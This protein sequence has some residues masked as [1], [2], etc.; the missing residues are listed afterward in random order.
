[1]SL[2]IE[3]GLQIWLPSTSSKDIFPDNTAAKFKIQLNQDLNLQQ[4]AYEC[5]LLELFYNHDWKNI[6]D[7]RNHL[8]IRKANKVFKVSIES[9]YYAN[10]DQICDTINFQLR[11]LGVAIKLSYYKPSNRISIAIST[12]DYL[13][14][15]V[16]RKSL[17]GP[18]LGLTPFVEYTAFGQFD[19]FEHR[20][21]YKKKSDARELN[22]H[23]FQTKRSHNYDILNNPLFKI[24]PVLKEFAREKPAV[25]SYEDYL[26]E[27]Q[28]YPAKGLEVSL[29]KTIDHMFKVY[30]NGI[31][32][33]TIEKIGPDDV[34]SLFDVLSHIV[35]EVNE[36]K[37]PNLPSHITND[38]LKTANNIR[39]QSKWVKPE[40]NVDM[41]TIKVIYV[42]TNITEHRFLGRKQHQL[43]R[44]IRVNGE[45]L[46]MGHSEFHQPQWVTINKDTISQI[47]LSVRFIR[48]T[49]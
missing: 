38:M 2:Q 45:H 15:M 31:K 37:L 8:F 32:D 4:G 10:G 14:L 6:R 19:V 44:I 27:Y 40:G 20:D 28:K 5:A 13:A 49:N 9:G 3:D 16:D 33:K 35:K 41:D 39:K 43:L 29:N 42:Y 7:K 11:Q 24:E 46:E 1:M 18:M 34:I 26:K 25:F 36:N 48:F 30:E 12:E 22:D 23:S 17:L 47:H 21:Y